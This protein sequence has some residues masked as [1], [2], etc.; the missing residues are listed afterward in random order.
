MDSRYNE[1]VRPQISSCDFPAYDMGALAMRIMTKMLD[2]QEALQKDYKLNYIYK[3]KNS[4][5]L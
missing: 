4:T 5:K 3:P 1:M 2:G